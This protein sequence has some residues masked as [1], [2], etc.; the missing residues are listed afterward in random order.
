LSVSAKFYPKLADWEEKFM[1]GKFPKT[2][3]PGKLR[4]LGIY[5]HVFISK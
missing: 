3:T 2:K 1:I 4:N 5:F